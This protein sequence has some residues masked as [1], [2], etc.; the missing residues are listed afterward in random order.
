M[1]RTVTKERALSSA[2]EAF[3]AVEERCFGTY[4]TGVFG[5]VDDLYVKIVLQH[6]HIDLLEAYMRGVI[7]IRR[8]NIADK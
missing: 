1:Y 4:A 2:R 3:I 8:C 6:G 5:C 7:S